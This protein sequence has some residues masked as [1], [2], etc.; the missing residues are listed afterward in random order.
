MPLLRLPLTLVTNIRKTT[1]AIV[2]FYRNYKQVNQMQAKIDFLLN[3][4]SEKKELELENERLR[5]LLDFKQR[6]PYKVIACQVIGRHPAQWSSTIILNRGLSSGIKNGYVCVSF[7]GLVGRVY[8]TTP[9]TSTVM[10]ITDPNL[11]V[12]AIVQ[13]S[14]Q[15]GLVSGSLGGTLVMKYLSFDSDIKVGDL[16]VT[17]GLTPVFPKGIPIG[18]VIKVKEELPTL[19]CYAIIKPEV[20][21]TALEEVLVIIP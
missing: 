13:R 8:Q 20:D 9:T 7:L 14:R 3:Q 11:S 19:S 4:L 21:L 1:E 16:V 6:L 2:Y 12:S 10:L 5:K 15:E 17:S 18:K